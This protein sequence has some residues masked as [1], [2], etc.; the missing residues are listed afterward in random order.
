MAHDIGL[1]M[2]HIGLIGAKRPERQRHPPAIGAVVGHRWP[3]CTSRRWSGGRD[4]GG[5][6]QRGPSV[7]STL[8]P[9]RLAKVTA[10]MGFWAVTYAAVTL[11]GQRLSTSVKNRSSRSFSDARA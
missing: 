4:R 10:Y 3:P 8:R 5:L 9:A 11:R 1:A 6:A 2:V 7:N